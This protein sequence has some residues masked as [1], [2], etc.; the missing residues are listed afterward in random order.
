MGGTYRPLATNQLGT[1]SV[2]A[3][4]NSQKR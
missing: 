1:Q 3:L 2:L 4:V